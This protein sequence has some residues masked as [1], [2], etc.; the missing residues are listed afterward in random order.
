MD[1]GMTLEEAHT[2]GFDLARAHSERFAAYISALTPADLTRPAPNSDWSVG[3]VIAH[4]QSV[5][6]R[7]TINTQRSETPDLLVD[8]NAQD[9]ARLGVDVDAAVASIHAQLDQLSTVVPMV[10]PSQ[11]F[12]FH[13]GMKV[14]LA[15]GWG[16]L[17]GELLAHGDDI[18]VATGKPFTIGSPDLEI[19]P[20]YTAPLLGGWLS[21]ASQGVDESWDLVFPFGL[22]RFTVTGGAF[23][24]GTHV[25]P[26]PTH[27]TIEIDDTAE[28]LL[29]CPYRRRPPADEASAHLV[30][31]FVTL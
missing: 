10:D 6:E 22:I 24:H 26:R 28:W 25:D 31:Q 17:L 15:A 1:E 3:E 11:E 21:P 13:G 23:I 19:I 12:R 16:N 29:T 9:V 14:T 30:D 7:Y 27:H 5:Y 2:K 20:R 18:A 4:V 8:Q